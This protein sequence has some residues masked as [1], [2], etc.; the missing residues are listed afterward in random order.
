MYLLSPTVFSKARIA[1]EK[2]G[3]QLTSLAVER[4]GSADLLREKI[5]A[6]GLTHRVD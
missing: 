5:P 6:S 1:Q 4:E 2:N 3:L